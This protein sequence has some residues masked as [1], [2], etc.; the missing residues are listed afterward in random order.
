M[1][2]AGTIGP[3]DPRHF[4]RELDMVDFLYRL[5]DGTDFEP[6]RH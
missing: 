4:R 5:L 1:I 6:R 3:D 2:A